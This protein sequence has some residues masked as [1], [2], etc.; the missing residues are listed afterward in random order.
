MA[1][2][3]REFNGITSCHHITQTSNFLISALLL[4]TLHLALVGFRRILYM[5][6]FLLLNNR[7]KQCGLR[8]EVMH[9]CRL[10]SVTT[11]NMFTPSHTLLK[12][13]SEY[14]EVMPG[15][16]I[17]EAQADVTKPN[18]TGYKLFTAPI[19]HTYVA[20]VNIINTGDIA[21]GD[22]KHHSLF[23]RV[24][25]LQQSYHWCISESW[26]VASLTCR[27]KYESLGSHI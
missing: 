8:F 9:L 18:I 3:P 22:T 20:S 26:F 2:I 21:Q 13:W 24:L 10:S 25:M 19:C 12:H 6:P 1:V 27:A 15:T 7:V 5:C 23:T 11:S 14:A 17:K 16:L 4:I